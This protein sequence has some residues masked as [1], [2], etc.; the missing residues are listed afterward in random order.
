VSQRDAT[1]VA[2]AHRAAYFGFV[3][4]RSKLAIEDQEAIELAPWFE[5]KA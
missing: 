4:R 5:L 3:E 1:R 2:V